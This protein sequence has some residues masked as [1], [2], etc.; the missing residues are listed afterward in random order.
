[1]LAA[2]GLSRIPRLLLTV[3]SIVVVVAGMRAF[4]DQ[5]NAFFLAATVAMLCWPLQVRLRKRGWSH[6]ASLGAVLALVLGVALALVVFIL[7]SANLVLD[8]LPEYQTQLQGLGTSAQAA[9]DRLGLSGQTGGAVAAPDPQSLTPFTSGLVKAILGSLTSLALV[10]LILFFILGDAPNM[11]RRLRAVLGEESRL[12]TSADVCIHSVRR[13]LILKTVFG[14]MIAAAQTVLMLVMGVD[15]AVVWG[16]LAIFM[17]YIPNIGFVIAIIPPT[18][19]L[20]LEQGP[21][22]ALIFVILYT[23]INQAIENYV[24]PRYIG[25]N[26]GISPLLVFLSLVFWAWILGG[27]GALLAVPL[28]MAVKTLL[29]DPD[30]GARG[31]VALI[32]NGTGEAEETATS[33]DAPSDAKGAVTS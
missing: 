7:V 10:W 15:F 9:L 19:L 11:P 22:A 17:N 23:V 6:L 33:D 29:L 1:M 21:E 5:L 18:I 20:L 26:L 30:E 28:T 31:L 25:E 24:S 13:Y 12:L 32:S 27:V 3:A 4:S 8:K 14:T 2:P 16:V